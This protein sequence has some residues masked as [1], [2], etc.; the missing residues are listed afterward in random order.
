LLV[1][2]KDRFYILAEAQRNAQGIQHVVHNPMI[3]VYA[4]RFLKL[5]QELYIG[6]RLSE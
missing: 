3:S 5:P 6:R 4:I 2:N 1:E